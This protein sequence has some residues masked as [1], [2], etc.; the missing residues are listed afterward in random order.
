MGV[1]GAM[2]V[3][4]LLVSV[5]CVVAHFLGNSPLGCCGRDLVDVFGSAVFVRLGSG[6]VFVF[7][8]F[9]VV[10]RSRLAVRSMASVR[11]TVR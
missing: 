3:L 5:G 10:G 6:L 9:S 4:V 7:V 8:M 11:G 2:L 1:V